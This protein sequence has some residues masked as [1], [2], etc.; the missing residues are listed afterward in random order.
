MPDGDVLD[1]YVQGLHASIV[2]DVL[3]S[4]PADLDAAAAMAER[5]AAVLRFT[6]P[7]QERKKHWNPRQQ[8]N[9]IDTVGTNIPGG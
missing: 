5:V 1:H 7:R 4:M 9:N 8:Y 3:L 2:K 6:N